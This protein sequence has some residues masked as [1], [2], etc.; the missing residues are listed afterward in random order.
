MEGKPGLLPEHPPVRG[1]EVNMNKADKDALLGLFEDHLLLPLHLYLGKGAYHPGKS[2][3]PLFEVIKA[4][5]VDCL[6]HLIRYLGRTNWK[7]YV[8]WDLT[9]RYGELLELS[10]FADCVNETFPLPIRGIFALRSARRM[11]SQSLTSNLEKDQGRGCLPEGYC[12][13]RRRK[14]WSCM[15]RLESR[16]GAEAIGVRAE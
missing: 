14:R 9:G 6:V 4:D 2:L 5:P 16:E 1:H 8:L 13:R 7:E 15:S 3:P 10:T 11:S 12:M